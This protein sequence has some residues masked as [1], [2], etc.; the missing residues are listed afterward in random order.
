M[1]YAELHCISNFTFLRG[2]SHPAELVARAA[3]LGYRA[4]ALTDECS[5]AGVVRAHEAAKALGF[6]LI[7]GSEFQLADGPRLVLLAMNREGYAQLSAL[8]TTG[9]RRAPKGAYR[10]TRADL[11]AGLP[12]CLC[13]LIPPLDDPCPATLADDARWLAGLFPDRCWIAV[14]RLLLMQERARIAHL[15]AVARETALPLVACGDVHMHVRERHMLQDL[16]T[17]IRLNTTV[18]EAGLRLFPNGER[19][20][21][22]P[23]ALRALYRPEWLAETLRIAERCRFSLDEL[24]Y[25]YPED[26]VP[27]GMTASRHLRALVEDGIRHYWPEGPPPKVRKQIEH[28]LAVIAE[29]RYEHFFLTVHNIVRFARGRGILCQGRGSAANSAVC[30]CLHITA[31][32]PA[33]SNMLFERF[34]S[35]E[36]NEP[37]DIDV[38]F[39][40]SRREEVMQYIYEK[41]GRHRA[42][43]AATLIRYRRK[44]ALRDAGKALGLGEAQLGQLTRNLVW[45]ENDIPEMQLREAGFD[46]DN[47]V[48]RRVLALARELIGFPRHL[49]QHVGG[50][51]I[52]RDDLSRL[53]PVENAAMAD[54]TVIQWDKNDLETLGLLKVDCLALG[55]LGALSRCFALLR[56]HYRLALDLDAIPAGDRAT[57]AMIQRADT[58]GVFQIESRAQMNM[59]PRLKPRNFYDLVIQVAIVRPGPIQG[60][61]VHPYLRRRR[62]EEPVSYP[63]DEVRAVLERTLGVPIFQEQVIE[64]AMVAAG[65][66]GGEADQLRRAIGAWRSTKQLESFRKKL[67]GGMLRRGYRREFAEQI[68]E[69]IKGF[70]EYGFP[71]SHSASFALLAYVSAWLKCHYPAAFCCA[72]LNSQPMGFYAPAQL[73]QDARRHGVEVRAIDVRHS[74]WPSTLE[75]GPEKRDEKTFALRLGLHLV[76]GLGAEAGRRIAASRAEKP[77]TSVHDLAQRARLNRKEIQALAAADAL[78]GLAGDRHRAN[79]EALGVQRQPELFADLPPPEETPVPL[80]KPSEASEIIADYAHT[81]LTLRRHPM[82]LLRKRCE[83]EG[84]LSSKQI[85]RIANNRHGRAAGIVINRQ[86]PNAGGA[87]FITLEDEHGHIN[88]VIWRRVVEQCRKAVI[89]GRLLMVE[90]R[91][92]RDGLLVHLVADRVHDYTQWL[93]RL[94]TK[95][96]DFC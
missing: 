89:H 68:F 95:S 49:S 70:G 21:R 64:L 31:I 56:E 47:P 4:L 50:F 74:D 67:I 82:A 8:I 76:K 24:R 44:S 46:P 12:D 29:L 11:A 73:V 36:R 18:A 54:R 28:E 34:I 60:D 72:L 14:E 41:Y 40:N 15:R 45:W 25:E 87:I 1:D 66:S 51:I 80:P 59:L 77:F 17:A 30:Y 65:F 86:H 81:G 83:K 57:Y 69:Q 92:E 96:R 19:H 42:A 48:I 61:M 71:E 20:L 6:H 88:I 63:S 62:G 13:L 94:E 22:R 9:R 84:W 26:L 79:W 43:L 16:L 27:P 37:P 33:R 3:R 32:D 7:V 10:L 5:L 39:D 53:A 93:G 91:F 78:P 55:M 75:S 58:I 38:D 90:G 52:A 2:A 23:E 35:R 85:A